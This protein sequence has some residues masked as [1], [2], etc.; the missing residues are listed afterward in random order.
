M[1]ASPLQQLKDAALLKPAAYINGAWLESPQTFA[2]HDPATGVE[3]ARVPKLDV[4]HAE[5]AIAA[6]NKA[7]PAW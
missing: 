2:V 1:S 6:A 4:T 5:Q 3:L 7:W